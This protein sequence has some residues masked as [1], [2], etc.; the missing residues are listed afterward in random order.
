MSY[1]TEQK[2]QLKQ[3]QVTEALIRMKRLELHENVIKEF[4]EEGKLNLSENGGLLYWLNEK[5]EAMV[6][7][8]EKE[9]GNVVYHVIKDKMEYGLS[10]SYLYVSEDVEEWILDND[11]LKE[12]IILAYVKNVDDD[13][14]SEYGSIGIIPNIG[15]LKRTA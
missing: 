11:D 3:A 5:E 10:Y 7:A 2:T 8:W 6:R 13:S 4:Y 14:C 1:L 9:T 15:G 12:G